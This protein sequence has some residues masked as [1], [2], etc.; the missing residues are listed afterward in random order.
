M[1]TMEY[2]SFRS[3]TGSRRRGP[4]VGPSPLPRPGRA[5]APGHGGAAVRGTGLPTAGLRSGKT[6]TDRSSSLQG[7]APAGHYRRSA[8][9]GRAPGEHRPVGACRRT[10]PRH[11]G[12][13]S[14]RGSPKP[15]VIPGDQAGQT[16]PL[17]HH[18]DQRRP[19]R[20]HRASS[21]R[22]RPPGAAGGRRPGHHDRP[23]S[24]GQPSSTAAN[25]Q[26]LPRGGQPGASTGAAHHRGGH[27]RRVILSGHPAGARDRRLNPGV[28]W[29]AGLRT[30]SY[31]PRRRRRCAAGPPA[32]GPG[33]RPPPTRRRTAR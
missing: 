26:P 13:V 15:D 20:H 22:R 10:A 31:A 24:R 5:S 6:A 33:G 30:G 21:R 12:G 29:S 11:L 8:L 18:R 17:R 32:C 2:D 28:N 14:A 19:L 3:G 7:G 4:S 23:R 16:A 9:Q 25:T 27:V 1:S